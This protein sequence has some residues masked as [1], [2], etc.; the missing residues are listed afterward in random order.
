FKDF[1]KLTDEIIQNNF[2]FS[3]DDFSNKFVEIFGINIETYV[4]GDDFVWQRLRIWDNFIAEV[5]LP[6]NIHLREHILNLI[7]IHNILAILTDDSSPEINQE[8]FFKLIMSPVV[9]PE[10]VFP[11]PVIE[12]VVDENQVEYDDSEVQA[13]REQAETKIVKLNKAKQ[14]IFKFIERQRLDSELQA[15]VL[16]GELREAFN[17]ATEVPTRETP[18]DDHP[19]DPSYL[20]QANYDNLSD[21]TKNLLNELGLPDDYVRNDNSFARIDIELEEQ[22]RILFDGE[23][24]ATQM[25]MIGSD[26]V[27][28][29]MYCLEGAMEPFH[30]CHPYYGTTFPRGSGNIQPVGVADLMV[31]Q[32]KILKFDFGEV[33]HI[34]NILQ[35]E[36]K[37]REHRKL[38]RVE[39][40]YLQE[41]ENYSE[42]ERDTQTT[43]RFSLEREASK[44]IQEAN[45]IHSTKE[46]GLGV[47]LSA[48]YGPVEVSASFNTST[49]NGSISNTSSIESERNASSYAKEVT[50]KALKRVIER[51][52]EQRSRTTIDEVIEINSHGF[53]N[54]EG[55]GHVTGIYHWVDKY[56]EAKIV[57]YGKRLMFEFMIPEPAA[58]HIYSRMLKA[59]SSDIIIKPKHPKEYNIVN[60]DSISRTNYK[61][62]CAFYNV[63]NAT[64]PPLEFTW[65]NRAYNKDSAPNEAAPFPL[66]FSS[67]DLVVPAGYAGIWATVKILK[68]W[69][70]PSGGWVHCYIADHWQSDA[71]LWKLALKNE[72]GNTFCCYGTRFEFLGNYCRN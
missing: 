4:S 22:N 72:T 69:A 34:E 46:S 59:S 71:N 41:T 37:N 11:L 12:N 17:G 70:P 54:T 9:L 3:G 2:L 32:Q 44:I 19:I 65:V 36:K 53:D 64:P 55:T 38:K 16:E 21:D 31:V 47:T 49:I 57:N 29:G 5:I 1:D 18:T 27:E 26:W 14:E 15:K 68:S 8:E 6:E 66:T 13:K 35:S 30:P 58:F 56:Y 62:Y 10:P 63:Q 43:E 67:N 39:E 7:R 25:F 42:T 50:S 45:Q 28:M 24:G 33:A 51:V 48:G 23:S 61:N 52:R 20:T 60:A 40:Y